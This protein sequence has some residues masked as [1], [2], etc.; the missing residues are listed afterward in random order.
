M[1]TYTSFI[2]VDCYP[3]IS[4]LLGSYIN[5]LR[6]T[7]IETII[8]ELQKFNDIL[9]I[10]QFSLNKTLNLLCLWLRSEFTKT[11]GFMF[12]FSGMPGSCS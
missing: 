6:S 4:L 3:S 5:V 12:F 7:V 1:T 2:K 9:I 10:P 8:S 11:F